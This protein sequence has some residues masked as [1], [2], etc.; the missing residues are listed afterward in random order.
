MNKFFLFLTSMN[1]AVTLLIML[2]MASVI[3]TL[4]PQNLPIQD[5]LVRFGPF[6]TEVFNQLGVFNVYAS[7]WFTAL[8]LFLVFSLSL[9]FTEHLAITL[10]QRRQILPPPPKGNSSCSCITTPDALATCLS[11]LG[12][13]TDRTRHANG[14][15][16]TAHTKPWRRLGYFLLHGGILIILLGA[17]IDT[18]PLL[19]LQLLTGQVRPAP[20]SQMPEEAAPHAILPADSGAFRAS[21]SLR[22]GEKS[23]RVY[24]TTGTGY[25]IRQL[26]FVI[27]IDDFQI[28][29]YASGMPKGYTTRVSLFTPDGQLLVRDSLSVNHPLTHAGYTLYQSTFDD[30]GS[31]VSFTARQPGAQ[32][33]RHSRL[34]VGESMTVTL[35]GHRWQL[36]LLD[37]QLHTV[38]RRKGGRTVNYGPRMV[39]RLTDPTGRQIWLENYLMPRQGSDGRPFAMLGVKHAPDAPFRTIAVPLHDNRDTPFWTWLAQLASLTGQDQKILLVRLFMMGGFDEIERFVEQNIEAGDRNIMKK[40]YLSTLLDTLN[41]TLSRV[42]PTADARWRNDAIMAAD[43]LFALEVPLWLQITSFEQRLETGLIVARYPGKPL[44]W[45]GSLLLTAGIFLMLYAPRPLRIWAYSPTPADMT[46]P[47][48]MHILISASDREE[49]ERIKRQLLACCQTEQKREDIPTSE[50]E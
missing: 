5:Y 1:L 50:R 32:N 29:Y 24:L 19:R 6:W 45:L 47:V 48:K 39:Y 14:P 41:T 10:R 43:A 2:A 12:L 26:P 30:G 13:K 25:L 22:P 31:L 8:L 34:Q 11:R 3:G 40:L 27:A 21:I 20:F 38:S 16:L 36:A 42:H 17:L 7:G 46:E 9:C 23:D 49:K 33:V 4:I 18:N 28:D 44:I 35:Q 15:L 37:F